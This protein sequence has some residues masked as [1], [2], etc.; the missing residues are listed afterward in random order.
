M[1]HSYLLGGATAGLHV[2]DRHA[3]TASCRTPAILADAERDRRRRPAARSSS[4]TTLHEPSPAPTSSP[5]T[6]GCRWARRPRPAS[7]RRRS[8]PFR[9]DAAALALAA[10]DAIVLHCLPAY[11]GKEITAEV[12][13]GPQS[14]VWDEAENRL[15]AQKAL[16]TWLLEQRMSVTSTVP[17][18]KAARHALVTS[19]L[20]PRRSCTRSS[21]S[22]TLLAAEGVSRHAGH[23]LA[24]TSSS[25]AR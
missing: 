2:R 20:T 15:H 22:P 8:C 3:A 4:R 19:L 18:T 5:P 11:R 24:A 6:P 9:V 10:P 14:V 1:A 16:L 25:C 21:S 12:L 7:A 17:H 23:A 13:D